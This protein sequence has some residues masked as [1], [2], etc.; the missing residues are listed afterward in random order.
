MVGTRAGTETCRY[1]ELD[2]VY[3]AEGERGWFTRRDG[4][5]IKDIDQNPISHAMGRAVHDIAHLMG[6]RTIAEYVE[7]EAIA[8]VLRDIGIDYLQGYHYG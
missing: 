5:F 6:M 1:P 7:T 8:R 2:L 4:S 3:H